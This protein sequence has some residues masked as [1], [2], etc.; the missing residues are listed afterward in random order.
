ML[1]F[2]ICFSFCLLSSAALAT[3]IDFTQVLKAVTGQPLKQNGAD[4][5]TLEDQTLGDVAG[6]ALEQ[7]AP[8][9]HLDGTTKFKRDQLARKIY[10]NKSANLSPDEISVIREAIGRAWGPPQIGAAW[11]LLPDGK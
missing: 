1:R 8:D 4:G 11:P 5:R 7:A 10:G 9:E 2:A 6:I 3:E